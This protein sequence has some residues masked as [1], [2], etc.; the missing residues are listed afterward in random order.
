MFCNY[1]QIR[2]EQLPAL[3]RYGFSL[4]GYGHYALICDVLT[5]LAYLGTGLLIFLR[6]TTERISLFVSLL[7]VV[8]GAFGMSE[9]HLVKDYPIAIMSIILLIVVLKWPAREE[10]LTKGIE[11][12]DK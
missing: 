11:P 9:V 10:G 4:Q 12:R 8:F 1:L 6:K 2:E 3:A 7:L 5:T